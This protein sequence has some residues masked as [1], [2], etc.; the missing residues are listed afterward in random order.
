MPYESEKKRKD[1]SLETLRFRRQA[2]D[3]VTG[4]GIKGKD[5]G[6]E[7]VRNLVQRN[8][9]N[10]IDSSPCTFSGHYWFFSIQN[11]HSF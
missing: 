6:R 1:L 10:E 5:D 2:V 8:F 7:R 9:V 11:C 3:A 4:P